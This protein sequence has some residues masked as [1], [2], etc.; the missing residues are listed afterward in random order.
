MK[1]GFITALLIMVL[2][3]PGCKK[4]PGERTGLRIEIAGGLVISSDDID[5]YDGSTHL[6][7]LKQGN[8]RLRNVAGGSFAVYA[9]DLEI[10]SGLLL[11][12]YSSYMPAGPVMYTAPSLYGD[13]VLPLGFL[14]AGDSAAAIDP[15]NDSRIVKALESYDQ[16]R[17]GMECEI[18]SVQVQPGRQVRL[19]LRLTNH[20]EDDLYH[21][22]PD[23]MD[24]ALFHY[25][26]NGLFFR[27]AS[28]AGAGFFSHRLPVSRPEPAQGWKMEW[29]TLMK[30]KE[31]R[32]ITMVYP[33]FETV[34]PG[35]YEVSFTFPG[36]SGQVEK[37]ELRQG[38]GRIWLGSLEAT[39]KL[40]VQ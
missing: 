4:E 28:G 9:D 36:F 27:N 16:Y 25:F 20:D 35:E 10:Y 33:D 13:Y 8:D 5:F 26:T 22:D 40:A 2:A 7:Y 31:T 37:S 29:L 32:N 39:G 6:L 15:R 18:V 17:K 12:A 24:L 14:P 21:L 19:E 30:S 11:P 1:A 38:G 34:P 3:S 23:K